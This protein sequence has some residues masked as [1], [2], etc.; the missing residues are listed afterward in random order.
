VL[1]P[2]IRVVVLTA[3]M[4]GLRQSD[5]LGLRW[6]DVDWTEQRIRVRNAWVRGE[7]SGEG[8]S[9]LS[10]RRS[11]DAFRW[12][13]ASAPASPGL[14]AG[15]AQCAV[16]EDRARR[17]ARTHA[18]FTRASSSAGQVQP[19][20]PSVQAQESLLRRTYPFHGIPAQG[21]VCPTR[22]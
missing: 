7:H 5:L 19:R 3:A 21:R 13:D 10:T 20:R 11:V 16:R 1:G 4:T 18:V 15:P 8:K 12:E 17:A 2:V 22:G 9:D 14:R 6:R